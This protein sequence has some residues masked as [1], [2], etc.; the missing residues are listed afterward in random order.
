VLQTVLAAL[1]E[2]YEAHVVV[3]AA[4]A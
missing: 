3:D 4:R 1:R 2:G